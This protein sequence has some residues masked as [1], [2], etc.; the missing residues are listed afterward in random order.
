MTNLASRLRC[1]TP[2]DAGVTAVVSVGVFSMSLFM[3]AGMTFQPG[4]A[5]G[6][7][8]GIS[9]HAVFASFVTIIFAV[10]SI[11]AAAALLVVLCFVVERTLKRPFVAWMS[12]LAVLMVVSLA[13]FMA[14]PDVY[15][16]VRISI[17]QEWP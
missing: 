16:C 11:S 10:A 8:M 14:C 13:V 3:L 15:A 9:K 6:W 12:F 2:R 1:L 17:A 7:P 4:W 5:N